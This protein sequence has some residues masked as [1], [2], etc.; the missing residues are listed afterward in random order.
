MIEGGLTDR[1]D[2]ICASGDHDRL[3]KVTQEAYRGL[4]G[5]EFETRWIGMEKKR[6]GKGKLLP[7]ITNLFSQELQLGIVTKCWRDTLGQIGFT[8]YGSPDP[9]SVE[10]KVHTF[11]FH[12]TTF[13]IL[14]SYQAG[15][16]RPL[17]VGYRASK[18]GSYTF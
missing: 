8:N 11:P 9:T 1:I 13:K 10:P 2:D 3:L 17:V 6:E 7:K 14:A 16:S 4:E 5:V 12:M 18:F 15:V